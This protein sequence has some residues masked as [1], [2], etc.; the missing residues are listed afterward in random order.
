MAAVNPKQMNFFGSN[1]DF[2]VISSG[3]Y[4]F[5]YQTRD[6]D[7]SINLIPVSGTPIG[8]SYSNLSICKYENLEYNSLRSPAGL[9]VSGKLIFF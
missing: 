5:K 6:G 3:S 4:S 9:C 1:I 2:S 7:K 8:Y